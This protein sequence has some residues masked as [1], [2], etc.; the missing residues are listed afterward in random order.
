MDIRYYVLEEKQSKRLDF[1]SQL[2]MKDKVKFD[3]D[4]YVDDEDFTVEEVTEFYE[5]FSSMDSNGDGR[6]DFD[7]LINCL[8]SVG[9]VSVVTSQVF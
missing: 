2:G 8:S 7:A 9:L 5:T 3:P 1:F 6:I 4:D